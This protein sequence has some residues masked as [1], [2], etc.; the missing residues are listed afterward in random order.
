MDNIDSVI[1]AKNL[2]KLLGDEDFFN[3]HVN[4]FMDSELLYNEIVKLS[5]ENLAAYGTI[6]LTPEQLDLAIENVSKQTIAETFDDMVADGLI[7]PKAVD[8]DGNFLYSINEEVREE[9]EKSLKKNDPE[10]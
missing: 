1:Y 8:A 5:V 10:A 6:E 2:I 3:P 7:E 4:P 9:Y